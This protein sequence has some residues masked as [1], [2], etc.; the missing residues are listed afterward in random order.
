MTEILFGKLREIVQDK[1]YLKGSWCIIFL[2]LIYFSK[3]FH[4]MQGQKLRTHRNTKKLNFLSIEEKIL[5]FWKFYQIMFL[6]RIKVWH[7]FC[8]AYFSSGHLLRCTFLKTFLV[9]NFLCNIRTKRLIHWS[10][11]SLIAQYFLNFYEWIFK[12]CNKS[13]NYLHQNSAIQQNDQYLSVLSS[14]TTQ[15][16]KFWHFYGKIS[17]LKKRCN[18]SNLFS[19]SQGRLAKHFWK[20]C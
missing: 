11:D 6:T 10:H 19:W 16:K 17:R 18:C 15:E 9:F 12:K 13:S 5:P 2:K 3:P 4:N 14:I 1:S 20:R 7:F 8:N